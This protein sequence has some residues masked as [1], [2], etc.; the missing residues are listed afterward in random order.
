MTISK[1]TNWGSA[2]ARPDGL[3]VVD[4]DAELAAMLAD[5][6]TQP[7]AA[8]GGDLFTTM[9]SRPVGDRNELMAFPVD[10]V[11]VSLDGGAPRVAVAHVLA[12]LPRRRGGAWRGPILAVM[13]A[14]FIGGYDVAPRGH[15]NDGRV[16]ALSVAADMSVRHRWELRRR[17]R[18]ASHLPHPQISTR[19]VRSAAFTFDVPL[20]VAVDGI[21]VGLART[22]EVSV[23]PDAA[24]V[25]S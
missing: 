15:P 5:G 13:N 9:G 24:V 10:L 3:R 12:Q 19:S 16:E 8:S 23:R 2:V 6:S 21:E 7:V 25:H 4:T 22:I 17:L 18:N 1:G 20:R 14:E 11:D